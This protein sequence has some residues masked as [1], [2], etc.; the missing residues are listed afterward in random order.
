MTT[1]K[2]DNETF[3]RG[4]QQEELVPAEL[5]RLERIQSNRARLAELQVGLC[6]VQMLQLKD[7]AYQT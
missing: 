6:H 3:S 7:A 5:R 4:P 2:G 1:D